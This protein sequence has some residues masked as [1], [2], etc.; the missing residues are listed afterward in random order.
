VRITGKSVDCASADALPSRAMAP[1]A[2][3]NA[4]RFVPRELTNS[5]DNSDAIATL[6]E[7]KH[8][9]V[10]A[11]NFAIRSQQPDSIRQPFNGILQQVASIA[12]AFQTH[13]QVVGSLI[14][15][16]QTPHQIDFALLHM[17]LL[18]TPLH[19]DDGQRVD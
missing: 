4:S 14:M 6:R 18:A 12:R 15:R 2:A 1:S 8:C 3:K 7:R 19:G 13:R 9:I 11:N 17:T 10:R 5:A 16:I